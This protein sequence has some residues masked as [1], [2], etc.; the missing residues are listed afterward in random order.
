ML[1]NSLCG[2]IVG[3]FVPY[4]VIILFDGDDNADS[5][6]KIPKRISFITRWS[7]HFQ[8]LECDRKLL[9]RAHAQ[10]F[11]AVKS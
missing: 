9:S 5:Q 6:V 1:L 10:L 3:L 7:A 2:P 11:N 8:L 4:I